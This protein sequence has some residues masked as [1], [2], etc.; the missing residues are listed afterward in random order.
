MGHWSPKKYLPEHLIRDRTNSPICILVSAASWLISFV[1]QK[2]GVWFKYR[3]EQE[4]KGDKKILVIYRTYS[5]LALTAQKWYRR[6]SRLF[7]SIFN[8]LE[9]WKLRQNIYQYNQTLYPHQ[10]STFLLQ[11]KNVLAKQSKP[12]LCH[13]WRINHKR[14]EQIQE[15]QKRRN[16]KYHGTNKFRRKFVPKNNIAR[17]V[18]PPPTNAFAIHQINF[19]IP[20]K[21]QERFT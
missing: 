12:D 21:W 15:E 1:S 20:K 16:T 10:K 14:E 7:L 9:A 19:I 4:K 3:V 6:Y 17:L 11:T 18:I 2:T 13:V 5:L 8:T